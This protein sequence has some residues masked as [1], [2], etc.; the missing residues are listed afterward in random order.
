M[1][2]DITVIPGSQQHQQMLELL[3]GQ[4]SAC[5]QGCLANVS[6]FFNSSPRRTQQAEHD[7]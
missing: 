6:L 4:L 2:V 1:Q 3:A 5:T 7:L